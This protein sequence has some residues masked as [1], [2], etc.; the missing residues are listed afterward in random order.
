MT[1]VPKQRGDTDFP[2]KANL[3]VMCVPA[4]TTDS[5]LQHLL[6]PCFSVQLNCNPVVASATLVQQYPGGIWLHLEA[7][8]E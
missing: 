7:L 2:P 8:K 5:L 6:V 1:L 3:C 4:L